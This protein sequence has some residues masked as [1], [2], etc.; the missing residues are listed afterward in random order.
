M[1]SCLFPE[2]QNVQEAMVQANIAERAGRLWDEGY[3]YDPAT[4]IIVSPRGDRYQ[5][6]IEADTCSCESIKHHGDCKH[7]IAVARLHQ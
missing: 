7:R 5:V 4:G 1:R 2:P 3:S 6:D